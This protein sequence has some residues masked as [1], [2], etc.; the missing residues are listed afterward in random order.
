[1][2]FVITLVFFLIIAMVNVAIFPKLWSWAVIAGALLLLGLS[3]GIGSTS[4]LV[5]VLIVYLLSVPVLLLSPLRMRFVTPFLFSIFKK[6]TLK[7]SDTER[8]LSL[9]HI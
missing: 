8:E 6:Q 4:A 5:F 3:T 7:M 9:I 2:S 1:M